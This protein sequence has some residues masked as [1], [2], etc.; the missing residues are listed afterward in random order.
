MENIESSSGYDT[1]LTLV[2][3][4]MPE[5]SYSSLRTRLRYSRTLQFTHGSPN[6]HY[7]IHCVKY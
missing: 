3:N 7:R 4:L 2:L 6:Q 1:I 5:I